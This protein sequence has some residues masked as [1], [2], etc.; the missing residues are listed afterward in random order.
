M[1]TPTTHKP[2]FLPLSGRAYLLIAIAIL[3]SANAV[4]RKLTEI[5]EMN[6]IS[7]RNPISFCNVLFV[8]NLCALILLLVLYQKQLRLDVVRQINA[9]QW[10]NMTIVAILSA[11][12]V[13]TLVFIA[14]S[15]TSVNNVILIG[16]ID[17][18]LVLALSVLLLGDRINPWVIFGAS[19][20]FVGVT[21][22]VLLQP[23]SEA[24]MSMGLTLDLGS[25][26]T[27]VAAVFKA[28]ANLVSKI[29]LKAIPL[30]I[31]SVFRM[32]VGTM[33]FFVATTVLYGPEHF[34][35]AASPF[36]WQWMLIYSAIIVVGGQ[37]FWFSGLKQS[38]ASE[39]SL[40]TAFNP[41]TGVLAA[42]LILGEIPTTAQFI[43]GGVILLG[44]VFNQI[45][46]QRL[47]A[48]VPDQ[49]PT[50]KE[51]DQ[52]LGFKGV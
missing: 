33:V 46:V 37:F 4:V 45:G 50:L 2:P 26:L 36:L 31:F 16:Q 19:L 42:F 18:P 13:P 44:I 49:R 43:G 20:A 47:N 1:Q 39:I 15:I 40:A 24:M 10:F 12:V 22:T 35:D 17:T 29:S 14:L 11:A 52:S 28:I 6:L 32:M 23:P 25:I 21:L 38:S 51:M 41:I 30:G 7:G 8:G 48:T 5:G 3:G 27:L 9:K 34:M